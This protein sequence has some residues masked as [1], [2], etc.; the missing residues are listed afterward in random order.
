MGFSRQHFSQA[1]LLEKALK[2]QL[3]KQVSLPGK[4]S[5]PGEW[6]AIFPIPGTGWNN[7]YAMGT[8]E[9][10]SWSLAARELGKAG[11]L[12]RVESPADQPQVDFP[13][14][15]GSGSQ[16]WLCGW[17]RGRLCGPEV[18]GKEELGVGRE[19]WITLHGLFFDRTDGGHW[20]DRKLY[21]LPFAVGKVR[22]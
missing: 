7:T 1:D 18:S 8:H 14:M 6:L 19:G 4:G 22:F 13:W 20:S 5:P 9:A 15:A 10:Q 2:T 17:L 12:C 16:S 3:T 21:C 11:V